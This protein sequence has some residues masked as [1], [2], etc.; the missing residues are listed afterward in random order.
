M[1]SQF[2]VG[3]NEIDQITVTE[4]QTEDTHLLNENLIRREVETNLRIEMYN[5]MVDRLV[6]DLLSTKIQKR[7]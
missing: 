7:M 1:S 5:D 6:E 3:L 4:H 2:N